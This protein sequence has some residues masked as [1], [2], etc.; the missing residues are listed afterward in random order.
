MC[1][2]S[3]SSFT[4]LSPLSPSAIDA[5]AKITMRSGEY[6]SDKDLEWFFSD[7]QRLPSI[8]DYMDQLARLY[9]QLATIESIGKTFEKRDLRI[10]KISSTRS[11]SRAQK[12]FR[13]SR[14]DSKSGP[15]KM[16]FIDA[17]IHAREWLAPATAMYIAY[18]LVSKYGKDS[19]IT[20]VMDAFDFVILPA[21]NP[22]GYEYSHT[23]DRMWRKTRSTIANSRCVGVDP[24]RNFDF[25]WRESG[26]SD[27][28]CA[29]TYAGPK[30]F[31]EPETRAL[32]DYL[33]K[34]RQLIRVYISLHSYSQMWLYPWGYRRGYASSN[35]QLEAKA[36]AAVKAIKNVY[37]TNFKYG[38][39][40]NVLYPAAG[41]SDDYAL[42]VCG[43]P[44]AYTVELRPASGSS[45]AF[46]A[47]PTEIKPSGVE[48]TAGVVALALHIIEHGD[49]TH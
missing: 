5:N 2:L 28:P 37:G 43:I 33:L 36:K 9:P 29:E 14:K 8:H 15:K 4:H 6:R 38:P 7:F 17:G 13:S 34:N 47:S 48:T 22:D 16:V 26:T 24:N 25:H 31:S 3:F 35:A 21:A 12:R 23:R 44:Y 18:S 45:Q 27:R 32:R 39:S 46:L 20:R 1:P 11:T 41:G 49:K 40:A 42:G 10:I 30:A 19:S